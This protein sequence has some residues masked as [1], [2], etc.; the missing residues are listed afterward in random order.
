VTD[1][2]EL[3]TLA[4]LGISKINLAAQAGTATDNGNILGL[5]SSYETTDGATHAAADVWFLA[6]RTPV[7]SATSV[8]SAIAA[9]ATTTD[10]SQSLPPLVDVAT[11]PA[12]QTAPTIQVQP[13]SVPAPTAAL[14]DLRVQ[15]SGMAQAM[16]SFVDTGAAPSGLATTA[17]DG[18]STAP[19]LSPVALAVTSMADAMKQFDSSG[20]VQGSQVALGGSATTALTLKGINDPTSGD[21][22]ATGGKT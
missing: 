9:L 1:E 13:A 8:D 6:D 12:T 17:L 14:S 3:K 16:G 22:L 11:A 21:I 19:S 10:P 15:V 5:T 4:S 2:G 20:N 18:A 7:S